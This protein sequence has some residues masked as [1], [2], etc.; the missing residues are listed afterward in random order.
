MVQFIDAG[1]AY[2]LRKWPN[3]FEN[4][5]KVLQKLADN[6]QWLIPFRFILQ[7]KYVM[8]DFDLKELI[9]LQKEMNESCPSKQIVDKLISEQGIRSFLVAKITEPLTKHLLEFCHR[10]SSLDDFRSLPWE[11]ISDEIQLGA[12]TNSSRINEEELL[13]LLWNWCWGHDYQVTTVC[14]F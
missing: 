12:A 13:K 10:H 7:S 3:L 4:Y 5:H 11:V 2:L 1:T 6:H 9:N 14:T 8:N